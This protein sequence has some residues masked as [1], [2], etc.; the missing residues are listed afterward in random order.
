MGGG[1][2]GLTAARTRALHRAGIAFQL[3][4]GRGRLGG[5]IRSVDTSGEPS[6]DG[7]DLG[8]SW[9]WPDIQPPIARLVD[10]LGR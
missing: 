7:F 9:F 5:R 1:L 2:A 10:E 4:E 8:P 6:T 3:L